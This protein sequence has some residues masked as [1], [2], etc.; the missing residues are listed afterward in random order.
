MRPCAVK[1]C[2]NTD[3]TILAHRFPKKIGKTPGSKYLTLLI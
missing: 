3:L 1:N 2:T